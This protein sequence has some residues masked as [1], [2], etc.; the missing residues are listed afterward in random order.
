[1]RI[2]ALV[3]LTIALL[4]PRPGLTADTS[5]TPFQQAQA[6]YGDE[7]FA[8]AVPI[9]RTVVKA[10]P[11][12]GQAWL[13]LA[14]S[15]RRLSHLTQAEAAYRRALAIDAVA[16]PATQGLFLLLAGAGRADQAYPWFKKMRAH[17][18]GDL[19]G[20]ASHPEIAKLRGDTRFRILFAD[21]IHYEPPFVEHATIIHEWRGEHAG[22]EFGWI[23]RQ[24]GDVDH[25]GVSD[26]VVSA[27]A[28]PPQGD[29][30]GVIYL[31]SSKTG[32]LLWK[33]RGAHGDLLGNGVEAAGDVNRDGI[34][35]VIAGAPGINKAFVLSGKD[36]AV[37]L[38]FSGEHGDEGFGTKATGIGDFNADG[39]PEMAVS[40]P[41]PADTTPGAPDYPGFVYVYSG[42]DGRR[43][44]RLAG[45]GPGAQMGSAL[46]GGDGFLIVG[47]G[48]AGPK[49]RGKIYV[50]DKLESVPKFVEVADDTGRAL[51]A[52]FVSIAG[53]MNRDGV[54]D[55]YAADWANAANGR[56][57]GRVYV[58]SGKDGSK[59]ITLDGRSAGEGFGTCAAKT[60]DVNG[61]GIADLVVGSWQYA[62]AA[63]SGGRVVVYSGKDGSV[64]QSFTGRVP[65]ETLGFDAV[66][67]GDVNGDGQVDYLLAS[68]W[69]MVHG[70]RSG[71]VYIVAG[72]AKRLQGANQHRRD[73]A[74]NPSD[75]RDSSHPGVSP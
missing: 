74:S 40:A 12:N 64:L 57:S 3:L 63:W 50:Y 38:R 52:M 62:G 67:I 32:K 60:G 8:A 9:L 7:K 18:I 75:T 65:G 6:L 29:G 27:P 42:K 22:D 71:R 11:E 1:M 43:L 26:A 73:A 59:V 51:G 70:I 41:S 61:D 68:A 24:V 19:S 13:M 66:G 14:S 25:D 17:R 21:K 33:Y 2:D 53:D 47:A 46:S 49:H 54:P 4:S 39:Y 45:D 20:L 44:W 15:Q 23:A 31:Y 72:R 34:P 58:Y 35:D 5:G 37:L 48:G 10:D 55:I 30:T 69:S 28:H 56:S 36:G 16:H